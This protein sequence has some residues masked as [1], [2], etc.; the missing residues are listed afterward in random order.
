[1]PDWL[2]TILVAGG[3]IALMKWV[4]PRLGVPT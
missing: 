3:Y 1:M 4:L 2:M